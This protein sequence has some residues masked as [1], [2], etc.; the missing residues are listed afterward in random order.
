MAGLGARVGDKMSEEY[1]EEQLK[2]MEK[3]IDEMSH[4]N[5]CRRWRFSKSGDPFF[6]SD[7]PRLSERFKNRLFNELGGFTPEISKAIGW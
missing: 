6:R 1:S 4:E 3:E 7:I 5:L 2:A